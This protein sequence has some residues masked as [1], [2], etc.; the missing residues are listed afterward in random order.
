MFVHPHLSPGTCVPLHLRREAARRKMGRVLRGD[1]RN[2]RK[3]MRR[4]KRR[5]RKIK[6]AEDGQRPAAG[7]RRGAEG[8]GHTAELGSAVAPPLAAS[9]SQVSGGGIK[10]PGRCV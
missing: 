7:G 5:R 3:T 9:Y 4:K 6:Q 2:K 8:S 1:E 10:G